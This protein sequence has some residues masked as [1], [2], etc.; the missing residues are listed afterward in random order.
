MRGMRSGADRN[1]REIKRNQPRSDQKPHRANRENAPNGD[2]L[3][4][5]DHRV[6]RDDTHNSGGGA[7]SVNLR[8]P[9]RVKKR[10]AEHL[11]HATG[12]S[13]PEICLQESS[14]AQRLFQRFPEKEQRKQIEYQVEYPCVHELERDELPNVAVLDSL[15]AETEVLKNV[16]AQDLALRR[17]D[18][19]VITI[20]PLK[21]E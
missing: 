2:D 4:R 12:H 18:R 11:Q 5:I 14:C 13:G 19:I 15:Q 17:V 21:N 10:R 9:G 20:D 1:D 3:V 8:I 6:K 16:P 7:D